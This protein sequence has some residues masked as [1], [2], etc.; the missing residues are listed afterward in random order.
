MSDKPFGERVSGGVRAS[1]SVFVRRPLNEYTNIEEVFE[2]HL[3]E[4]EVSQAERDGT[5]KVQYH[6]TRE[7]RTGRPGVD[8]VDMGTGMM[9]MPKV[10]DEIK[11]RAA[12]IV[13]FIEPDPD[14]EDEE[15]E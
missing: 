12:E 14:W 1:A 7:S 5:A 15:N 13:D 4:P 2:F 8:K 6:L 9:P 3:V 10:P 11:K